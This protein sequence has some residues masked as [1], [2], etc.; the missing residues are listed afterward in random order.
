MTVAILVWMCEIERMKALEMILHQRVADL[1][2]ALA[3]PTPTA[4][5]LSAP[6]P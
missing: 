6:I 2:A 5:L 4:P 3:Y 1:Q